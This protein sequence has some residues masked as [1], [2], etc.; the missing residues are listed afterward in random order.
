[1]RS[2]IGG[3]EDAGLFPDFCPSG[4][5]WSGRTSSV[6]GL[7]PLH[8]SR[9]E[10]R[11]NSSRQMHPNFPNAALGSEC[12]SN[13]LQLNAERGL[14]DRIQIFFAALQ[15]NRQMLMGRGRARLKR[16]CGG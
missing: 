16:E 6:V 14:G 2:S 5:H 3:K 10:L 7:D 4:L 11:K 9:L 1:M 12:G 13:I 15:V 8:S